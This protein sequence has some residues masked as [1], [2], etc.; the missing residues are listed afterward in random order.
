MALNFP[1]NPIVGD[2][3][4]TGSSAEYKY[5]DK[6][7]WEIVRPSPLEIV[8]ATSASYAV[9]ASYA[10]NGGGG[11]SES[12][13]Y[14]LTASYLEGVVTSVTDTFTASAE[15]RH[16]ITLTQAEYDLILAK[17]PNTLYVVV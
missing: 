9:T 1:N 15:V 11:T 8:T 10:L 7:Y 3:Y 6:N 2:L 4:Q 16:I 5:T 12:A 13:S 14:A 17:D